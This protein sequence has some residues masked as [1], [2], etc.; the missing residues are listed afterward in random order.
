M[1]RNG[2]TE[3]P[4]K[5]T[6]CSIPDCIRRVDSLGF[7]LRHYDH[8]KRYGDPL[9]GEFNDRGL[10]LKE[11]LLKSKNM[12]PITGCW[13]WRRGT[14]GTR[15]Y[16]VM[17]VN[18]KNIAVHRLSAHVFLGFDINSELLICHKCDTPLCFNPDHLFIGTSSDNAVDMIKKG[19]AN[20]SFGEDHGC[21]KYTDEQIK[22]AKILREKGL[23]YTAIQKVTG[24]YWRTVQ[25]VCCGRQWKHIN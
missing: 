7:C 25:E 23:T 13:M 4:I 10:S 3:L 9:Y 6:H 14:R 11:R 2:T 12:D 21:N 16:G 8:F 19:R 1:R 20:K 24:V 15:K 5:P 17:S 18:G 22:E